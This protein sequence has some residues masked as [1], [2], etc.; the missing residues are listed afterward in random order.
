M[1]EF[2]ISEAEAAS[3]LGLSPR[4]LAHWRSTG[5]GPIW[6]KIGRSVRYT[7]ESLRSWLT[8][9]VRYGSANPIPTGAE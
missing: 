3:R 7:E 1:R 6:M 4:T 8:S 5:Q 9:S 2:L